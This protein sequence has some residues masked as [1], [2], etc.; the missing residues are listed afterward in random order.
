MEYDWM[1]MNA[2]WL[3]RVSGSDEALWE[4]FS[5]ILDDGLN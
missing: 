4:A 2:G 3:D 5:M 1:W